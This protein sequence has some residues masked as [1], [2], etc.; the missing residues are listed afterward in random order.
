M[1]QVWKFTIHP[2]DGV[3]E[4]PIGAE[5]LSVAFQGED[6]VM[7]ALVDIDAPT[8]GR[9]FI[10][11]GTGHNIRLDNLVFIGTAFTGALVFHHVFEIN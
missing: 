7:W 1:K 9:H 4:M 3:T 2:D 6:L 8:C 10:V 5:P 11:R